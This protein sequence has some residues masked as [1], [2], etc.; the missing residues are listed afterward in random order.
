MKPSVKTVNKCLNGSTLHRVVQRGYQKILVKRI[1]FVKIS[2][3]NLMIALKMK[4][5]F[6]GGYAGRG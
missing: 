6:G 3:K 2:F 4:L 1:A 5:T